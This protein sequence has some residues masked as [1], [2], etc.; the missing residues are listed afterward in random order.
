[1]CPTTLGRI[2]T[3]TAILVL[4]AVLGAILSVLTKNEG[5]IV[6]IGIY[7]LMGVVL[8][9]CFYSLIIRW[10]PP[11]LTFALAVGEFVILYVLAQVLK[12][13]LKPIDAV[14]FYWLSW[15]LAISTKIVVLPILSLTWIEDG[16]EF[17][18]ADW[19]V[20]PEHVP[21]P[22]LAAQP[23]TP[24][25]IRLVREFSSVNQIPDELRRVPSPSGV[26]PT[27]PAPERTS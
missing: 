17:R 19:S 14:W 20:A 4:P 21:L 3:R 25:E 11:W 2:Q 5:F 16:G 1:M 18:S 27:I 7:L 8:D 13:G 9:T 26:H 23:A 22:V 6:L 24:G 12:V 15:A 10:Q